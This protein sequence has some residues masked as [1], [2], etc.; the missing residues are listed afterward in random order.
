[1]LLKLLFPKINLVGFEVV[2]GHKESAYRET[3]SQSLI[4]SGNQ[5]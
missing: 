5:I 4:D 2:V 1:M 3:A